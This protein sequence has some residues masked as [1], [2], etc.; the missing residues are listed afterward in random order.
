MKKYAKI[1]WAII[2][3]VVVIWVWPFNWPKIPN[4][5]WPKSEEPPTQIV[6]TNQQ[7]VD[8]LKRIIV[9]YEQLQKEHDRKIDSLNGRLTILKEQIAIDETKIAELKKQT[10]EKVNNIGKFTTFDISNFLSN[11][12]RDSIG[13]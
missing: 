10:N 3:L 13:R 6:V 2:T 4:I 5:H 8:S 9:G 7:A 1:V 11:R 12:Y